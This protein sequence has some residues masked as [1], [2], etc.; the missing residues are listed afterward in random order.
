[1]S[2]HFKPCDRSQMLL[3][4]PSLD[5]WLP[6]DHLA[7]FIVDAV[8]QFDLSEFLAEYRS[9]GTGQAAFHP[10]PVLA[11]LLYWYCKGERSSRKIESYCEDDVASRFIMANQRPDHSMFC[12]FRVWHQ[13]A[14]ANVFVKVLQL[15]EKAGMLKLGSVSLDGT[16]IKA[17]AALDAN[18]KLD[19]L[20]QEVN[21]MLSEAQAADQHED[22]LYGKDK[23]GDELP[24]ELRD[25]K[26][27][28]K[29][30]QECAARLKGEH[31][32]AR[33][34]QQDKLDT[35]Q[36]EESASGKKLRGRKPKL[37]DAVVDKDQ[38]A[39]PTDPQSRILKT[40]S[41]YV[42]GY[43]AQ[44][45]VTEAQII[46]AADVVNEENDQKQLKP[47]LKQAQ[48]NLKAIGMVASMGAVI[49]DAGYC[50]DDNLKA[51]AEYGV[52]LYCATTKDWKQRQILRD[53]PAPR[54]RIPNHL[55]LKDRMERK[56]LTKEG[57]AIYK[58]RGQT[59]EP[60]FGQIKVVQNGGQCSRRGLEA[61][62]SEWCFT[63]SAHNLLKLWRSSRKPGK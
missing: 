57:R 44:A 46:I 12:R 41:G 42:Q 24:N 61:N 59:V 54:G 23:R 15:C 26:T 3:L 38:K 9:D 2:Y 47:M 25:P 14:L 32:A 5:E 31:E 10:A 27:R 40:R 52:D 62:R 29:R 30:L 55:S 60:V 8:A 51:E 28:L 50:S 43:N 37:P 17:S 33:A 45:V 56:L 36:K 63:C 58:K 21:Q 7:R 22:S 49:V 20:E 39:N 19:A 6:E 1:M 16:K 11:L 13:K 4:P 35:R 34:A 18:R 53:A 48:A